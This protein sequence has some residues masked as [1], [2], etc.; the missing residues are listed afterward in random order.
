ME[1][2]TVQETAERLKVAPVT[3]RRSIASGRLPAVR[4]GRRVRVRPGALEELIEPTVTDHRDRPETEAADGPGRSS[5]GT[6][7]KTAP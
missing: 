3:V 7:T 5:G 6:P 1:L 2:L 4:V